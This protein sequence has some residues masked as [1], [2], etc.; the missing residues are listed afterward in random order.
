[1]LKNEP[2]F[3]SVAV[4]SLKIIC[5]FNLHHALFMRSFISAEE[6]TNVLM[7]WFC[8]PFSKKLIFGSIFQL[9]SSI[10][11][12]TWEVKR[13]AY[14]EDSCFAA[15]SEHNWDTYIILTCTVGYQPSART[16]V[17]LSALN[18]LDEFSAHLI[19]CSLLSRVG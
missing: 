8:Q 1:M 16:P 12:T 17:R 6:G 3:S 5:R 2:I 13:Y 7:W 18:Q 15:K 11:I 4:A 19:L 10:V 9:S 14:S